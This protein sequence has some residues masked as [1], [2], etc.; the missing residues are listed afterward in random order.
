M[1]I[2]FTCSARGEEEYGKNYA[3][4][5]DAVSKLGHTHVSSYQ[6][7]N[8]AERIYEADHDYKIKMYQ[9]HLKSIRTC[10]AVILE[11]SLHSLSMG[12][13]MNKALDWGKPVIALHVKDREPA[14]A[15]GIEDEKLQVI[16]YEL[17][18]V[19]EIIA[20]ALD[21]AREQADIR[22]NFFI[23]PQ[24]SNYLDWIS[25]NKRIP[26]SVYLRRLI[27]EDMRQ[28]DDYAQLT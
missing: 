10:D 8:D 3:R 26:R 2:Y 21:Y 12:Y 17:A 14:F 20:G 7:D 27:Q 16:E 5:H 13:I 28:N 6:E 24:I 23:S 11:V 4:I 25:K 9:D 22:F 18:D 1:K 19:Q 15:I